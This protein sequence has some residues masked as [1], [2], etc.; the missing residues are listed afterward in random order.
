M[1]Q[2]TRKALIGALERL[3]Q[4]EPTNIE[5]KKKAKQG[6]LKVNN[7]TVEKEAELSVG[8]LRNHQDIKRMIKSRSL[9]AKAES[10]DTATSEVDLLQQENKQL[11]R[12]KTKL[13]KLK[14]KHLANSRKSEDALAIQAAL[15]IKIVQELMEILP[16]SEREKA[17]DKIVNTGPDNIIKGNFR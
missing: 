9:K 7:N 1:K 11:K 15:H 3:I 6:K 17:M 16:E 12:D 5:L 10:S 8:S 13:N 4:G 14:D 2:V